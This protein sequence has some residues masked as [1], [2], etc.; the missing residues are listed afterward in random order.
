M[1]ASFFDH[2]PVL[3]KVHQQLWREAVCIENVTVVDIQIA[4]T[5][6]DLILCDF[7]TEFLLLR[8]SELLQNKNV[9]V[10]LREL[11][12]MIDHIDWC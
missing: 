9:T 4:D 6:A 8:E 7:Q 11:G 5:T 2:K 3:M 12:R 1:F 10:V